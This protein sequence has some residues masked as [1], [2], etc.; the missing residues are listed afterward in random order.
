MARLGD[1]ETAVMNE[2]WV[3]PDGALARDLVAVLPSGPAHTTVLTIL[4]RLIHKGH[5][6]R[7]RESRA[8]RYFAVRSKDAHV[9]E[10]MREAFVEAG[11]SQIALTHFLESASGSELLALRNA[12]QA[13]DGDREQ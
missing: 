12:L 1:L 6:R 13:L 3:R 10:L 7:V 5:V 11:D 8:H 9:A 2:L 4:E